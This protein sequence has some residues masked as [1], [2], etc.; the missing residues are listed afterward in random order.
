[1]EYVALFSG[2]FP[3][4]HLGLD[5]TEGLQEDPILAAGPYQVDEYNPGS[6]LTLVPN[7]TWFGGGPHIDEVTFRFISDVGNLPLALENGEV[8]VIYPQPQVDLVDQIAG[9][10]RTSRPRFRRPRTGHEPLRR[11]EQG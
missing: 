3:P 9:L 4:A 7:P 2:P 6:D 8:D 5:W 11:H 10:D 1:M